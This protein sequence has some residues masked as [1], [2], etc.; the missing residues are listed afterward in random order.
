MGFDG[1][2][3]VADKVGSFSFRDYL[4]MEEILGKLNFVATAWGTKEFTLGQV[5]VVLAVVFGGETVKVKIYQ[6]GYVLPTFH[7]FREVI[8][9]QG[10]VAEP[11]HEFI[12]KKVLGREL[13][14]GETVQ[15]TK[16]DI[17][18]LYSELEEIRKKK[19]AD[20]V[21]GLK[22]FSKD[23]RKWFFQ[24]FYTLHNG[25]KELLKK[26]LENKYILYEADW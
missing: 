24:R 11:L 7:V 3:K 19:N 13:E 5:R 21:F 2:I 22:D 9:L 15:L 8:H 25:L 4:R 10:S 18:K 23:D 14:S 17:E 20:E 12:E 16:A 6:D 1:Y 26:D